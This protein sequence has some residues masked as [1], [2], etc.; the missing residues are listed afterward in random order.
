MASAQL[1]TS[2][3]N[4][5]KRRDFGINKMDFETPAQPQ[6]TDQEQKD[7]NAILKSV[8]ESTKSQRQ[9]LQKL[10]PQ[11]QQQQQYQ[12][13]A[14]FPRQIKTYNKE[15]QSNTLHDINGLRQDQDLNG[16]LVVFGPSNSV[17]YET[18]ELKQKNNYFDEG[19]QQE[20]RSIPQ[21][22]IQTHYGDDGERIY[23]L[24]VSLNRLPALIQALQILQEKT[25]PYA[26]QRGEIRV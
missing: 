15:V 25:A 26:Y 23:S 22:T 9:S 4:A 21:V 12:H 3:K 2:S 6:W 13:Q 18:R 24:G 16:L 8:E 19:A 1:S 7:I 11:Q 17:K 20:Q 5:K 10:R 14:P